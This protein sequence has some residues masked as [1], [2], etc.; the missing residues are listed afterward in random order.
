TANDPRAVF[1]YSLPQDLHVSNIISASVPAGESYPGFHPPYAAR[2]HRIDACFGQF[3]DF[4]KRRGRYDR[5]LIIVTAD[6]GEMLGE[7]GFWGHV[8]Y[9]FPPVVEVP[10]LVHLPASAPHLSVDVDGVQLTTDITP[11]IYAALGYLPAPG[12]PLLG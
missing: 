1:A 3:V 5:S 6:H 2:V 12:R 11:T 8:Y 7:E 9:L 4:L 10:L